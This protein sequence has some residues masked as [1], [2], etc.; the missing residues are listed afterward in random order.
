[1]SNSRRHQMVLALKRPNILKTPI[2]KALNDLK[3]SIKAQIRLVGKG[4]H[5][6]HSGI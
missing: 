5:C 6:G 1:M 2:V 4:S 3:K